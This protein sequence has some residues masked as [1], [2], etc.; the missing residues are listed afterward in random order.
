VEWLFVNYYAG[1]DCPG[2]GCTWKN[3]SHAI[4]HLSYIA[5]VIDVINPD[6]INF[7]EVEGCDE[8]NL[9]IDELNS[10]VSYMPYLIKGTDT[11]TGQN[12]GMIT[13]IDPIVSLYRDE[14]RY[15]YPVNGS[16]CGY[17][18]EPSSSGVSKHYITEFN[19]NNISIAFIAAHLIAIPTDLPRCAHREAQA[20]VLQSVIYSYVKRGYEI[21]VLGDFNDYDNEI[22]DVNSNKPI[23]MVLDILKG[24]S[25]DYAGTYQLY[26]VGINITQQERYSDWWDSDEDCNTTSINDYS[27]IDHIIVSDILMTYIKKVFIYHGYAEY[28]GKMN[29]DH[30]PIVID[31]AF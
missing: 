26:S 7:C 6:I 17:D 10:S 31:L 21:I 29:S 12:V 1:M 25:G 28:C 18:G 9:V 30:F 5:N 20:S 4:N 3:Q 19:I 11:S 24:Y 14:S 16:M 13:R 15:N 23:S 22:L 27:T 2:D 8:L